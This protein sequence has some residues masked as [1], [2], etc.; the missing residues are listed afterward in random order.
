LYNS[1]FENNNLIQSNIYYMKRNKCSKRLTYQCEICFKTIKRYSNVINYN[2]SGVCVH[3]FNSFCFQLN[4]LKSRDRGI[5]IVSVDCW[6]KLTYLSV[7]SSYSVEDMF[8]LERGNRKLIMAIGD[9]NTE[10]C[11]IFQSMFRKFGQPEVNN[12]I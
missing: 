4:L 8:V 12:H 6:N 7:Y 11:P 10:L 5:K 3:V 9:C 1:W 2:N